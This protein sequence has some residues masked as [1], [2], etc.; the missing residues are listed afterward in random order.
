[1]ASSATLYTPDVLAL[2]TGLAEYGWDPALPL[3]GDARSKSCGSTITLGLGLDDAG[4]IDRVGLRSQACAIGQA[5]AA[6]FAQAA[7]GRGAD[8]IRAADEAIAAW[9]AGE[10]ELPDWPGL[11]AIAAARDY[12]ARHGALRLAWMAARQLL[13]TE[14]MPR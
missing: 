10:G 4:R 5:A 12:P 11:A 3:Q 14:G 13:P 2:A 6:I 8:D 7:I 9:L 1:M